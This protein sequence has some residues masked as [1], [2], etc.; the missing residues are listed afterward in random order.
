MASYAPRFNGSKLLRLG[1][2]IAVPRRP[3][4]VAAIGAIFTPGDTEQLDA[5]LEFDAR[6]VLSVERVIRHADRAESTEL[7]LTLPECGLVR[8]AVRAPLGAVH[9]AIR[10][11]LLKAGG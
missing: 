9:H 8:V 3:A 11:A 4:T 6:A 5:P 2:A 10:R 7:V 1:E